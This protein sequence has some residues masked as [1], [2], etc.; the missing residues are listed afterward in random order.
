MH[1]QKM[2]KLKAIKTN[3]SARLALLNCNKGFIFVQY[4]NAILGLVSG[5]DF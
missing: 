4:C 2:I 3:S 1:H 5:L